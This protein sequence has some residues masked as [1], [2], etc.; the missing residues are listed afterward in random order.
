MLDTLIPSTSCQQEAD[1][2]D[3]SAEDGLLSVSNSNGNGF[4]NVMD[5]KLVL[6]VF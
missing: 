1:K 3:V 6:E 4:A 5:M 2:L